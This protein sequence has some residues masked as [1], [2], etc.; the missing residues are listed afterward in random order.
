MC[1]SVGIWSGGMVDPRTGCIR[2]LV[3]LPAV[4]P[5]VSYGHSLTGYMYSPTDQETCGPTAG[6]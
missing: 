3:L 1:G 5:Y 4:R 2:D 6:A